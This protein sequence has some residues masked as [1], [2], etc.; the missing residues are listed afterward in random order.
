MPSGAVHPNITNRDVDDLALISRG[1]QDRRARDKRGGR[2]S[3]ITTGPHT[4]FR[5][6]EAYRQNAAQQPVTAL[7][8][9]GAGYA[10]A[11][12]IQRR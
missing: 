11:Y 12:L 7:L 1:S 3:S 8:I 2:A 6:P 4:L 5:N 10:L 9:A